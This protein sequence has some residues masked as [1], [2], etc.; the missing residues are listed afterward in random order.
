MGLVW[1][2]LSKEHYGI[3]G[4]PEPSTV[5][6]TQS[7]GCVRLT[8]WDALKLA[9][10]VKPG[11]QSGVHRVTM[12]TRPRAERRDIGRSR[13][14]VFTIGAAYGFVAGVFATALLVWQF[15]D[16]VARQPAP[17]LTEKAPATVERPVDDHADA[18]SPI[19]QPPS[20]GGDQRQ[21]RR[22]GGPFIGPPPAAGLSG[23]EPRIA[24]R[25]RSGRNS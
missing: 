1:I 19:I 15:G 5:G 14:K 9:G 24:G 6:K 12:A 10:L 2:D 4:T 21:R 23:R 7:H 25:G 13:A 22:G 16:V 20:A 3:H 18:D 17:G 11:T 8:N